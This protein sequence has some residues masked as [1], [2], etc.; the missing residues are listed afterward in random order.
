VSTSKKRFFLANPFDAK[1]LARAF[2]Q[3]TG[4]RV[5]EAEI[6]AAQDVLRLLHE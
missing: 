6:A 5:S 2:E 3:L 4:K 1:S